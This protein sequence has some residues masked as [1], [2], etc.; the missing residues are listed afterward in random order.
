V[1]AA[2][3]V[4]CIHQPQPVQHRA[5][6][7]VRLR[8]ARGHEALQVG[9]RGKAVLARHARLR[10]VQAQAEGCERGVGLAGGGRQGVA[11]A[12]EGRG[13]VGAVERQQVL[14]LLLQMA[15][16]GPGG[17]AL[18]GNLRASDADGPQIRLHKRLWIGTRKASGFNPSR[19]PGRGLQPRGAC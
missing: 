14:G 10:V 18:H 2:G 1:V 8:T 5:G 4:A 3:D 19:G 15:D 11:E 9:P 6:R 17:N 12:G 7:V 13:V 16:V